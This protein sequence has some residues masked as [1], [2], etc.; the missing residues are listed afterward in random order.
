MYIKMEMFS[1]RIL[2]DKTVD[3][4]EASR[5]N[6]FE[7]AAGS[8]VRYAQS[9]AELGRFEEQYEERRRQEPVHNEAAQVLAEVG[10]GSVAAAYP[11]LFASRE[12]KKPPTPPERKF[13]RRKGVR[14]FF[15]TKK[16]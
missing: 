5:L 12:S 3:A 8:R 13:S 4:V 14:N 1:G 6:E 16:K 2:S 15:G 9:M 10:A 7:I 11:N